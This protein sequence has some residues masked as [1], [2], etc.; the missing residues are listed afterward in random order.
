VTE[1]AGPPGRALGQDAA[2]EDPADED[3]PRLRFRR[4]LADRMGGVA[5]A[6]WYVEQSA[7]TFS[8]DPEARLVVEELLDHL[9]RLMQF[10]AAHDDETG[11]SVWSSPSAPPLVVSAMDTGDAIGRLG[12]IL[13]GS[14]QLR[15][16]GRL[17]A[18][19][20]HGT[21]V[22]LCGEVRP[23]LVEQAL[24]LRRVSQPVRLV[25]LEALLSLARAQ[26]SGSL[27]HEVVA[28]L[29]QP[30]LLAD[31][32]IARLAPEWGSG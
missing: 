1:A 21:L 10:D 13:R 6:A 15:A 7:P 31:P 22:V 26:D 29:L 8:T 25:S 9:A 27:A 30:A 3:S 19:P 32:L 20:A 12:P 5:E 11:L 4:F 24:T 2:I 28:A 23:R 16:D 14:D 18:A 17:P